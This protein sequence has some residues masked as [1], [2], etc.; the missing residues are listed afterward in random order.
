MVESTD[1][2][3]WALTMEKLNIELKKIVKTRID[4]RIFRQRNY[5]HFR[6]L[7]N[8][9]LREFEFKKLKVVFYKSIYYLDYRLDNKIIN[10][11]K[12]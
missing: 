8:K 6:P 4:S 2:L 7:I 5:S 11:I 12:K 3:E 9:Y 10:F 1:K